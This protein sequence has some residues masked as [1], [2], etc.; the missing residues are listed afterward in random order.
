MRRSPLLPI[1]L[2]IQVAGLEQ[3]QRLQR[4]FAS[5]PGHGPKI[6]AALE[7]LHARGDL[8]ADLRPIELERRVNDWLRGK[9]YGEAELP[10]RWAIKR[11]ARTP[12]RDAN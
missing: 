5:R 7:A 4:Q 1:H 11:H 9:G 12:A 2:P 6:K 10:S 3:R 8:P